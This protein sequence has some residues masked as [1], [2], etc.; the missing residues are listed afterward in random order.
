[1]V[2]VCRY[3]RR[4][5]LGMLLALAALDPVAVVVDDRCVADVVL[6]ERIAARVGADALAADSA[7]VVDIAFAVDSDG[8][9]FADVALVVDGENVGHRRLGPF[10]DCAAAVDA[11]VLATSLVIDPLGGPPPPPPTTTT[12]MTTLTTMKTTTEPP[13]VII[14]RRAAV[15]PDLWMGGG[16]GIGVASGLGPG[17]GPTL[18]GRF[19]VDIGVVPVVI[20]LGGRIDLPAIVDIDGAHR[21][22]S[23]AAAFFVDG[24][25]RQQLTGD[26]VLDSCLVGEGGVLRAS[27]IGYDDPTPVTARIM[28][29]GAALQVRAALVS[30][31]GI[32]ARAAVD[33]PL[34]RARVLDA[35]G[36]SLWQ[37]PMAGGLFVV[38]IDGLAMAGGSG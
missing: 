33:A 8:A 32:F 20:G 28:S 7:R 19:R 17:V 27:G 23:T 13:P 31:L 6:L 25:F 15:E 9:V 35:R 21:L 16:V 38:G 10:I 29:L 14:A 34:V 5:L 22:E 18:L 3:S 11:V 37:S 12:T 4:V 30:G 1:M 26:V 2:R 36:N 24:C